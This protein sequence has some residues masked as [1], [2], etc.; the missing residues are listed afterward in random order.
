ME[1][2]KSVLKMCNVPV[3]YTVTENTM[4]YYGNYFISELSG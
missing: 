3:Q 4:F 2:L 1:E